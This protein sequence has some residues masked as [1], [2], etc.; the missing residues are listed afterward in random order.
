MQRE[1]TDSEVR[2]LIMCANGYTAKGT[3][4]ECHRSE[5]TISDQ[6]SAAYTKLGARNAPHAVAIAMARG[7]ISLGDVL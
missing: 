3:A 5:H 4:R 6:L 1:L 2:T 7:I